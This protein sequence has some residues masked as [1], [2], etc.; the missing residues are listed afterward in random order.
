MFDLHGC[1][2]KLILSVYLCNIHNSTNSRKRKKLEFKMFLNFPELW[3]TCLIFLSIHS[4][5]LDLFI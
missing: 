4:F 5:L 3:K 2:Q 1:L